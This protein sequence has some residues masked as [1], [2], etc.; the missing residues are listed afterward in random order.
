MSANEPVALKLI[1]DHYNSCFI[2]NTELE[3]TSAAADNQ[4][5]ESNSKNRARKEKLAALAAAHKN[6]ASKTNSRRKNR[7]PGRDGQEARQRAKSWRKALDTATGGSD[8]DR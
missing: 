2:G 4:E 6:S 5:S 8:D 1:P 7:T 3:T